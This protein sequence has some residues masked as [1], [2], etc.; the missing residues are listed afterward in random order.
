MCDE[1][2]S[3]DQDCVYNETSCVVC[4]TSCEEVQGIT[5]VCGDSVIDAIEECDDG[6]SNSDTGLDACRLDCSFASC[7]DGVVDTGETCDGGD[8]SQDCVYGELSCTVCSFSCEEIGGTI[9]VCGDG[10][11]DTEE[12]VCDD[13][14]N[15]SN[16]EIDACRENCSF[17]SCGDGVLDTG[18]GCD[19][20]TNNSDSGT[21]DTT[22]VLATCG[23]GIKDTGEACDEGV[24]NSDTA[25]ACRTNCLVFSC[26]DGILD[27]G[28][29]CDNGSSNSD[30]TTGACRTN[31]NFASCG[32]GICDINEDSSTCFDCS[33]ISLGSGHSCSILN[34]ELF[35]WGFN[36]NGQLGNAS[37]RSINT[38]IRIGNNSDWTHITSK[39]YHT[40]GIRNNGELYCWVG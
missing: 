29:D 9:H 24:N 26:G 35:C 15:N 34:G 27:T 31:C 21:C 7:G 3:P 13:G 17:A 11:V 30:I 6:S 16:T 22:C 20:G 19:E 37:S 14:A 25:D 28:E 18:E 36:N 8:K 5:H 33:K 2:D 32:D 23:D 10:T 12:E 40:C 39:N 38:P 4:S 1:G